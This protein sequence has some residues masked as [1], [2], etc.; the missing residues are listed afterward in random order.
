MTPEV[1]AVQEMI[2]DLQ[3]L[4]KFQNDLINKLKGALEDVGHGT[5]LDHILKEH[6]GSYHIKCRVCNV[7]VLERGYSHPFKMCMSCLQDLR[8][9]VD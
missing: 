8:E 2:Y 1:E 3:K 7:F 6:D 5:L 4:V 9:E